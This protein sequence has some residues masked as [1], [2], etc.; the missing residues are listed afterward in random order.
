MATTGS[1][2]GGSTPVRNIIVGV[3]T[4][5]LG[6]TAVYFLGFHKN[7]RSTAET[8]LITKEVTSR[9]WS[10]YVSTEN[11]F[12]KNWN[13]VGASYTHARFNIYKEETLDELEKFYADIKRIIA[14]PDVDPK[15]VSLLERRLSAKQQWDKKYRIHL[16][17]FERILKNTP[18]KDQN[19]KINDELNRFQ[20]DVKDL[21]ARF[22]NEL[23]NVASTL[24]SKYHQPFSISEL[25]AF[26]KTKADT[27]TN[28]GSN[29]VAVAAIDRSTLVGTWQIDQ[30]WY[31]YHYDDGR[32]YMYFPGANGGR[33]STYGTW[34]LTNNQLYHYSTYY[35]NAGNKWVYEVSDVTTNGFSL[36]LTTTPFTTYAVK[37]YNQ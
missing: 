18:E 13:T 30:S 21:D 16:D 35:F 3:I 15:L 12:H 7:S 6:S 23:E 22:R 32:L 1:S 20:S 10:D 8:L 5:V 9:A 36:K 24:T 11:I 34:Q 29:A 14:M 19:Q 28:R 4:T 27:M 17:N 26:Q 2:T 25:D 37:R 31:V 33:D